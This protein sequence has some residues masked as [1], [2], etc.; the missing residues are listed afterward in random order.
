MATYFRLMHQQPLLAHYA[1]TGAAGPMSISDLLSRRQWHRYDLYH[2]F[3][4]RLGIQDQL[5]VLV[6]RG[7]D[8]LTGVSFARGR[9]GFATRERELLRHLAPVLRLAQER[10]EAQWAA[11]RARCALAEMPAAT[12]A[13][14]VLDH[15]DRVMLAEGGLLDFLSRTAGPIVDGQPLPERLRRILPV[16]TPGSHPAGEL[17][18][19]RPV[20]LSIRWHRPAGPAGETVLVFDDEACAGN[21][22]TLTLREREVLE[23]VAKGKTNHEVG[24]I[25]GITANTVRKHLEHAF[26]ELGVSNRTGAVGLLQP[27]PTAPT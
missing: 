2:E 19:A 6:T 26:A 10:V 12:R 20:R 5:A 22:A 11:R 17:S 24:T 4:R 25:L 14:I 9:R 18:W 13:V 21:L 8:C 7:P 23:W 1:K 27:P 15:R 16:A 3:F